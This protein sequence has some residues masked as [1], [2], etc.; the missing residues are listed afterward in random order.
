MDLA[1]VA[2]AQRDGK[3]IADLAPKA[4]QLGEPQ[5]VGIRGPPAANQARLFDYVLDVVAVTDTSRFGER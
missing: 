5:M 1:M 2:P 3:L 4:A